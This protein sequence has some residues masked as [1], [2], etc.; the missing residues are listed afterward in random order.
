MR[1]NSIKIVL[2]FGALFL[3]LQSCLER[4][5][6]SDIPEIK[7][8]SFTILPQNKALLTF[9]FTDGDGDIGLD[10]RD[11]MPPFN[12]SS[13][14]YYNFRMEYYE[15]R[16]GE[17]VR[18]DITF[19]GFDGLYYRIPNITPEGQN[20]ILEGE[21][22]VDLIFPILINEF[23]TCKFTFQLWDRALNASNLAETP[24]ILKP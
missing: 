5:E 12:L 20:K 1:K 17:W 15:L 22:D 2:L 10:P 6:F 23:D 9:R 7:F 19:P 4:K 24:I 8:E 11:T 18:P 16:N 14:Y 21:I 13:F 3:L